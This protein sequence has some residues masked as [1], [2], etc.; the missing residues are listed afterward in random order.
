MK[1]EVKR[2]ALSSTQLNSVKVSREPEK[3]IAI[4]VR[5]KEAVD[6]NRHDFLRRDNQRLPQPSHLLTHVRAIVLP[7]GIVEFVCMHL[8]ILVRHHRDL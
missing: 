7:I 6:T 2:H 5:T 8:S 4:F 3:L 1:Q